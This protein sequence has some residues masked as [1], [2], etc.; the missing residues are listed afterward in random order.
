MTVEVGAPG[1]S[2]GRPRRR[3]WTRGSPAPRC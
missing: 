2:A 1:A 3:W